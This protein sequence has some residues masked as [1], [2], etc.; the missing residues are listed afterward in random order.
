M[1]ELA[2]TGVTGTSDSLSL[3]MLG[4]GGLAERVGCL[5]AGVNSCFA[6]GCVRSH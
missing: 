3:L 4:A 6:A 5:A 2:G 1:S